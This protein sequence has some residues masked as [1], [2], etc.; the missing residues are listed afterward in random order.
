MK[1]VI[2]TKNFKKE[3]V[4][5]SGSY[6]KLAIMPSEDHVINNVNYAMECHQKIRDRIGLAFKILS[7]Y[8]N[9]ELNEKVGG[10]K[11]SDHKTGL[12][13]DTT[14]SGNNREIAKRIY[15]MNF[16]FIDKIIYYKKQN[17]FHISY[18]REKGRN[19]YWEV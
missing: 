15:N 14:T 19:L 10:A 8:R 18:S 16:K 1:E 13:V 11:A 9:E 3:E 17:F 4:A 5:V 12:A 2:E 7:W 6:P